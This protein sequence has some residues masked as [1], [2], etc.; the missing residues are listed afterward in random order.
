LL[1]NRGSN[2][3]QRTV[4]RGLHGVAF[5]P[6]SY[7]QMKKSVG[8][9]VQSLVNDFYPVPYRHLGA[10]LQVGLATDIGG[11]DH[12]RLSSKQVLQLA[13]AQRIGE[14][15]MQD[16]VGAGGTTAQMAFGA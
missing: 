5:K 3:A 10:G 16:R 4:C 1:L 12:L 13:V 9:L 14:L 7:K 8:G 6:R 2:S 11:D 15:R